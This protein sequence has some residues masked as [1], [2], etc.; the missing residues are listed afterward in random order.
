MQ[1][2][3]RQSMNVIFTILFI[4]IVGMSGSIFLSYWGMPF[5]TKLIEGKT[6]IPKP[7]VLIIVVVGMT[8]GIK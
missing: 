2:E 5:F 7:I 4:L 8:F 6:K 3:R 1:I